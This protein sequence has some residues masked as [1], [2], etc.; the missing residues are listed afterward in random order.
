MAANDVPAD[1]KYLRTEKVAKGVALEEEHDLHYQFLSKFSHA[2]SVTVLTRGGETWQQFIAPV[3][4][5][6][7]VRQYLH[8]FASIIDA[9]AE[10][11]RQ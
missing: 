5:F 4:A 2:S 3:L 6:T 1:L 8:A 7:G 11:H 10:G 9:M